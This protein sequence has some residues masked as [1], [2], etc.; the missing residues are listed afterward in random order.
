MLLCVPDAHVE[1][2]AASIEPVEGTVV[3]HCAGSLGL[4]VLGAHRR[5][6]TL[7]PLVSLPS[8]EIGAERLRGAWY[9]ISGDAV[10]RRVVEALGG[11]AVEVPDEDRAA[12]HAAAVVASNHLVALM[13][14]VERIAAQ[15]DVPLDAF[16]SLAVRL[17]RERRRA[18][19]G[20][21]VD[22][23]GRPW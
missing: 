21:G 2:V 17:A 19:A 18:G 12:Y 1:Q 5:R 8:P 23:S 4:D 10:S 3:A 13:G 20:G 22:R 16:L 6:A 11:H 15:I 9:G 14:Q 7:H